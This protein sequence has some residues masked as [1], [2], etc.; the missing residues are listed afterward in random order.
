M[1]SPAAVA[2]R[3][4]DDAQTAALVGDEFEMLRT[5]LSALHHI[6]SSGKR[7]SI[8]WVGLRKEW[9]EYEQVHAGGRT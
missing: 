9:S 8:R 1:S 2:Q 7:D 6:A 3:A 5:L 4:L